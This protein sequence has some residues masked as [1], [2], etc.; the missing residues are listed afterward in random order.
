M[1]EKRHWSQ[2]IG[3]FVAPLVARNGAVH[4]K[5]Q[6]RQRKFPEFPFR[7]PRESSYPLLFHAVRR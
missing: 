6:V 1:G 7:W 4:Q 3:Q 5:N 2:V